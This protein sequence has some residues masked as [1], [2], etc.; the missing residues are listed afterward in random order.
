VVY[1]EYGFAIHIDQYLATT[2]RG[3]LL[4]VHLIQWIEWFSIY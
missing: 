2:H 1:V 3:L 4:E